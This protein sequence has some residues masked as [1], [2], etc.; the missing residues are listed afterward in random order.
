ME[1]IPWDVK[2]KFY[3]NDAHDGVLQKAIYNAVA[4]IA[5]NPATGNATNCT[6]LTINFLLKMTMEECII[7]IRKIAKWLDNACRL[8]TLTWKLATTQTITTK[9]KSLSRT[10][11]LKATSRWTSVSF[12][13]V[14]SKL[15][16]STYPQP[17]IDLKSWRVSGRTWTARER[18]NHV[19][20]ATTYIRRGSST[21]SSSRNTKARQH[22]RQRPCC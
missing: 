13:E 19:D 4:N 21:S 20:T 5:Q 8:T 22:Q 2:P 14:A 15:S 9:H 1:W 10:D 6:T 17:L 18:S 12:E 7:F 11:P 3:S 16:L